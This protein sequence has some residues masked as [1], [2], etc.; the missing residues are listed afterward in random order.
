MGAMAPTAAVVPHTDQQR[1]RAGMGLSL[2]MHPLRWGLR[3][4][5]WLPF[6]YI[7]AGING[8]STRLVLLVWVV[9]GTAAWTVA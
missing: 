6:C 9:G 2:R 7:A 1:S 8:M 5:P 4:F 3:I